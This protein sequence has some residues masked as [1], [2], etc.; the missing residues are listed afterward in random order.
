LDLIGIFFCS[1]LGFLAHLGRKHKWL[2]FLL[3]GF[4]AIFTTCTGLA[5]FTQMGMGSSTW[6][7]EVNGWMTIVAFLLL[8]LPFRKILSRLLTI[9]DGVVSLRVLTGPLRHKMTLFSA[10]VDKTIFQAQS[11]PHL[12]GAFSY[13]M[14]FGLCLANSNFSHS[15]FQLPSIPLP[16]SPL[17]IEQLFTYNGFGLVMLS[18]CGV[19]VI[20]TRGWKATCQRLGW[21]KPTWGQVGIGLGL[22]VFSFLYDLTW[23][24]ATHSGPQDMASKI[25]G[26]N[27]GT[28][29]VGAADF[30]SSVF[31]AMATALCAG[32]GEETLIRGAVQPALGIL[33]AAFL[34]GILHAQFAQAPILIL[35]IAIWSCF[36]G[37]T[38]RFT[39]TTTTIIGHAGFN[40]VT[41]FLFAYNP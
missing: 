30:G 33:P 38:R 29:S 23:S 28:F 41:T 4:I 26:Y 34:H 39:N 9:T 6:S 37:L 16:M 10:L 27:S 25:S 35:Q 1:V 11:L 19:G 14:V 22:V 40:L 12:I 15:G 2:E 21:V 17:P 3:R 13:V 24:L 5:Y 8:F 36:M 31:L 7:I 32:I 20:V 18:L